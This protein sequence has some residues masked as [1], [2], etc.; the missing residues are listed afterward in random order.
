MTNFIRTIIASL[1]L[2]AGSQSV[3]GQTFSSMDETQ[4]QTELTKIALTIY[5]NPKFSKYY[6][7]YGYCG[8]SEI[9]TYNIKGE[10]EDK[11]RKEYLGTQQYVV[12]L[13]CKKG[14]D[15]GEFPIAKVYVSDKAGK[16]WMIRFGNDNMMFPYWNFQRYSNSGH[17]HGDIVHPY[18]RPRRQRAG[19]E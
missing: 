6:S 9:S 8:R 7:K 18:A 1:L 2:I 4:R 11:D 5:K 15:W 12:K 19:G 16:A 14:A 17:V 10:G 13:Y 3:L